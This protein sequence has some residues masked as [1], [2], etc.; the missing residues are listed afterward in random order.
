[1]SLGEKTMAKKDP[2]DLTE[3]RVREIAR[4]EIAQH[5]K[6]LDNAKYS[7]LR[8]IMKKNKLRRNDGIPKSV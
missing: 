2:S 7:R 8:E 3:A 6:E 4:E 1:M 5:E